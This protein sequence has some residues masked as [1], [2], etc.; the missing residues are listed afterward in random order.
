MHSCTMNG[1]ITGRWSRT[2]SSSRVTASRRGSASS[3]GNGRARTAAPRPTG[4]RKRAPAAGPSTKPGT[5]L[6]NDSRRMLGPRA[7]PRRQVE[8][9]SHSQVKSRRGS[10]DSIVI[11]TK[12]GARTEKSR[13]GRCAPSIRGE[14]PPLRPACSSP[15]VG[16]TVMGSGGRSLSTNA[17]HAAGAGVPFFS[18]PLPRRQL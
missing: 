11:S 7:Q 9:D 3:A 15:S 1:L 10:L 6:R 2:W 14:I 12:G 17:K 13:H 18:C 16:M 4:T 8:C 5:R